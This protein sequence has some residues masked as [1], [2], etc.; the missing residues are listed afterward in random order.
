MVSRIMCH[1]QVNNSSQ[2]I[3]VMLGNLI[4]LLFNIQEFY[5]LQIDQE[6]D[7]INSLRLC[8]GLINM[9]YVNS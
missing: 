1:V 3:I 5:V 4:R 2:L 8:I 6:E 9:N 7:N